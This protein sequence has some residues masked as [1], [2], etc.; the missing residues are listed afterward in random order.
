MLHFFVDY[1]PGDLKEQADDTFTEK[2]ITQIIKNV[3]IKIETIHLRYEDDVTK[4]G[5]PFG[6]GVTLKNLEVQ[7]TNQDWEPA[8]LAAEVQTFNKVLNDPTKN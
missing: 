3:Q 7:T 5:S 6:F 4:A 8:V 1:F 2:L